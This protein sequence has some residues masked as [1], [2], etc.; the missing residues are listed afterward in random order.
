MD[1]ANSKAKGSDQLLLTIVPEEMSWNGNTS[2]STTLTLL[3]G[4][5]YQLFS[6]IKIF[7]II[8][9]TFIYISAVFYNYLELIVL[10]LMKR[11]LI[12]NFLSFE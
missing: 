8:D 11:L 2:S 5:H 10:L 1:L 4:T 12:I 3:T 7:F 9:K 6:G